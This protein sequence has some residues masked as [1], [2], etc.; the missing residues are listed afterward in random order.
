MVIRLIEAGTVSHLRSQTIYHGLAYA[1]TEATPPTIVLATPAEPYVCVGFHQDIE[2]EIDLEYC[3]SNDLPVL[4][5]ETGGGAVYLDSDQ[6]F[7]QWVI[8]VA[9]G[10]GI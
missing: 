1:R 9:R 3:A 7:V 10:A 6:L 2:A 8:Y 5:R 4:R